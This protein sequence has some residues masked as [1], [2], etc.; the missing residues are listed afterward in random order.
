MRKTWLSAGMGVAVGMLATAVAP[1][2]FAQAGSAPVKVA[3]IGDS[4]SRA[5]DANDGCS[6]LVTCLPKIGSD[7]NSSWTTGDAGWSSMRDQLNSCNDGGQTH[8][9]CPSNITYVGAQDG[10][11]WMEGDALTQ[12][13]GLVASGFTTDFV[14]I[15]LGGNDVCRNVGDTL[16]SYSTIYSAVQNAYSYLA[17][18]LHPGATVLTAHMPDIMTLYNT[19]KN[20]PQFLEGSCQNLWNLGTGA[21][22]GLISAI[23]SALGTQFPC[24]YMLSTTTQNGNN[25]AQNQIL[26][27]QLN[28]QINSII[29]QLTAQYNGTNNV[30][31]IVSG[32]VDTWQFAT[33]DVSKIDCFHPSRQGQTDLANNIWPNIGSS[34]GSPQQSQIVFA[35]QEKLGTQSYDAHFWLNNPGNMV[36][37]LQDCSDPTD[38]CYDVANCYLWTTNSVNT[39]FDINLTASWLEAGSKYSIWGMPVNP[40]GSYNYAN[41]VVPPCE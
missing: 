18:H 31:F 19:M 11:R 9:N 14:T 29:D 17:A 33:S 21:G 27:A 13:T 36:F 7:L 16:P 12:A 23:V 25:Q 1:S 20:Q 28:V 37:W 40:N 39:Q 6:N 30:H 8:P 32:E 41:Q 10:N 22:D 34:E 26:G 4:I 2:A 35:R 15:E 38:S 24:T 5:F 3:S